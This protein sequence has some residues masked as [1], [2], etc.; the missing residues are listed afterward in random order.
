MELGRHIRELFRLHRSMVV[1]LVLAVLVTV[2]VV[3]QVRGV[4]PP[5]LEP[6]SVEMATAT[7]ELLVDTPHSAVLDLRQG[8]SELEQMTSR[9]VLIGNVL[10]SPPVLEYVA[11]RAGVPAQTIRAQPPLTPDFPRPLG[12]LGEDPH[13]SDLLK[14][15]DQYRLNIQSNPTVP[16]LQIHAQAPS[17][18]TAETLA[19]AAVDGLSDYLQDTAREQGTPQG[20]LVRLEQLGRTKGAVINGG[21]RIQLAAIT[22]IVVFGLS[23]ITAM[24]IARVRQGWKAA[25]AEEALEPPSPFDQGAPDPDRDQVPVRSA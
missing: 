18:R 20:E 8:S 16:I 13:T 15:T 14:S 3:Y 17:A 4:L 24:W 10:A 5:T 21:V 22:F 6:R 12:G 7:T 9:A 2:N 19:N 25:R 11:R 1:C 23:A